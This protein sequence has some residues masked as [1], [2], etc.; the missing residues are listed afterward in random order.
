MSTRAPGFPLPADAFDGG[1]M[2]REQ[3]STPTAPKGLRELLAALEIWIQVRGWV[4]TPADLASI[5]SPEDG[6]L[7]AVRES[8]GVGTPPALY[9]FDANTPLWKNL[10]ST[11]LP[12]NHATT[13]ITGADKVAVTVPAN[14]SIPM[15][16]SAPA[17]A[18][19]DAWITADAV[20]GTS[21]LR[22]L[23]AGATDACAGNDARLSDARTPT[24]H[25]TFHNPGGTDYTPVAPVIPGAYP[26]VIPDTAETVL[27]TGAGAPGNDANLPPS[28][29]TALGRKIR[30][31]NY[32]G[33]GAINLVPNGADMINGVAASHPLPLQYDSVTVEFIGGGN[34]LIIAT[35]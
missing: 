3:S 29:T 5:D 7:V 30:L 8:A 9:I 34:W 15:T 25:G 27:G 31:V 4:E 11:G 21:S 24:A 28:A 22:K 32:G 2:Y 10:L 17:A 19:L 12:A 16:P 14:D 6:W 33:G 18:V 1:A 13:H 26:Y 20:A 23:G 35:T